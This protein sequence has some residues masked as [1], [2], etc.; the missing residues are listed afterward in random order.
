MNSM[1]AA[2]TTTPAPVN[3]PAIV[4]EGKE[5]IIMNERR[6]NRAAERRFAAAELR[7]ALI[8]AAPIAA[9]YWFAH[10]SEFDGENAAAALNA[11]AA[12]IAAKSAALAAALSGKKGG[13]VVTVAPVPAAALIAAAITF[14]PKGTAKDG[15]RRIVWNVRKEG[16]IK[17]LF[18]VN[19]VERA[20]DCKESVCTFTEKDYLK[21]KATPAERAPK[22]P[23]TPYDKLAASLYSAAKIAAKADF[24]A[25]PSN[26]DKEFAFPAPA[27]W[28]K[29]NT[30]LIEGTAALMGIKAA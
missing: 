24:D 2:A 26:L 4:T 22:A 14:T 21:E 19:T 7:N 18:G 15:N 20:A 6:L 29:D 27:D 1:N 28:K 9:A 13:E 25:V 16:S 5:G 30:A 11:A 12:D 10:V 23:L 8:A 17:H 3:A